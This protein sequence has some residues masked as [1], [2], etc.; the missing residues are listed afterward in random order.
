MFMAVG[1]FGEKAVPPLICREL[2]LKVAPVG[3]T[4][5]A[6]VAVV[7]RAAAVIVTEP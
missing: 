7:P 6:T 4:V 5:R 2:M 1:F 3:A